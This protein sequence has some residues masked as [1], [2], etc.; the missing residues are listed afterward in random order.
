M[1]SNLFFNVSENQFQSDKFGTKPTVHLDFLTSQNKILNL[2]PVKVKPTVDINDNQLQIEYNLKWDYDT[3]LKKW[4]DGTLD[5]K[6]MV[7]DIKEASQSEDITEEYLGVV[8]PA[9]VNVKNSSEEAEETFVKELQ[10]EYYRLKQ[11]ATRPTR[12]K[13]ILEEVQECDVKYKKAF[14]IHNLKKQ[15]LQPSDIFRK[16]NFMDIDEKSLPK[17]IDLDRCVLFGILPHTSLSSKLTDKDK[18]AVLRID[19]FDNLSL[20]ARYYVLQHLVDSLERQIQNLSDTEI[21]K[22][23][24]YGRTPAQTL[25]IYQELLATL[26]TRIKEVRYPISTN[27]G[28]IDAEPI[29]PISEIV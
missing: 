19:N 28:S 13:I 21:N 18:Q 25:L 8:E 16:E 26:G 11:L 3:L 7:S 2:E 17:C 14:E 4:D 9:T 15:I 29:V 22:K 27:N 5:L 23:D 10:E 1:G 24:Q 6:D 20:S 12:R